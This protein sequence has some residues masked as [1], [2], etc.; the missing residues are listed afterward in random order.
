[1]F[2]KYFNIYIPS[3]MEDWHRYIRCC[4]IPNTSTQFPSTSLSLPPA[5][6]S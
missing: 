3:Q 1:M 2:F 6:L 4:S 5:P